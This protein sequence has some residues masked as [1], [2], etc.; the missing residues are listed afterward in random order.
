MREVDRETRWCMF[1][2]TCLLNYKHSDQ[3]YENGFWNGNWRNEKIN[4]FTRI[5]TLRRCLRHNWK[6]SKVPSKAPSKGIYGHQKVCHARAL[7]QQA[8]LPSFCVME[9]RLYWAS[10]CDP[11]CVST[12]LKHAC[13]WHKYYMCIHGCGGLCYCSRFS[14]PPV[15]E[16]GNSANYLFL[17]PPLF[18]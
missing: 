9:R 1:N 15:K 4:I 3:K 12:L 16:V 13:S 10:E 11:L 8:Y 6:P 17:P 5:G 18:T 14:P 7:P 2:P